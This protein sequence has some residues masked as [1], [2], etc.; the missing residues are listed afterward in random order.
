MK[1]IK[2]N[3]GGS[4]KFDGGASTAPLTGFINVDAKKWP[5]VHEVHDI[6]RLPRKWAGKVAEI[7]CSHVIEHLT[8]DDGVK[9]VKHW[10]TL[11]K[12][13]GLLRIYTPNMRRIAEA[14]TKGTHDMDMAEFSRNIF[15]NQTYDLNLHKCAYDQER[16][17][18][19][20][21]QAGLKIISQNPRP[22]AYE[23]CMGVQATK[24]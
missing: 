17:N 21:T 4:E 14:L 1:G 22:H 12:P 9:A 11:L 7:R 18:G 2:L 15:G 24:S 3:L 23:W 13:G 10:K 5:G 20:C 16:L 8:Y 19:L 6:R